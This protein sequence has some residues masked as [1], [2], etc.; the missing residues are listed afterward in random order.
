MTFQESEI[1]SLIVAVAFVVSLAFLRNVIRLPRIP[2]IYAA[3]FSLMGGHLFTVAED[4]IWPD[5]FNILEH[6]C[7]ALSGV[8]FAVGCWQLAR[9][10]GGEEQ[11]Q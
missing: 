4:V 5:L 7:Y 11:K 10:S 2:L 3:I 8:L 9:H 1:V 6:V